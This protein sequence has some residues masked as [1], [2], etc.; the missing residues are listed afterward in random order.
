MRI[1]ILTDY[2]YPMLG[3]ITEHVHGQA[4]DLARRGHEVTVV[5]GRLA[6]TP[7]VD[8]HRRAPARRATSSRS[9]ASALGVP[10]YG[11]ASQAHRHGAVGLMPQL[12]RYFRRRAFDVVHVHAPYAR[13]CA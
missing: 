9:S 13:A 1:A 6:R 3:G 11:N 10:L 4:T 7:P 8:G 5:T 2:Y 12:R